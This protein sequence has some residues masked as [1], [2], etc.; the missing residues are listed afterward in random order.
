M[1]LVTLQ[2]DEGLI[3]LGTIIRVQFN[4]PTILI[5]LQCVKIISI[6]TDDKNK[7]NTTFISS[8]KYSEKNK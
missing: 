7:M 5:C 1:L 3:F 2:T 6:L 8:L 4:V